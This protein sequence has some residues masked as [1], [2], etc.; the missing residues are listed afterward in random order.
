[1]IKMTLADS[2]YLVEYFFGIDQVRIEFEV[3]KNGSR[4]LKLL[5]TKILRGDVVKLER[6]NHDEELR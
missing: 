2:F 6:Q 3:W 5:Q 1:M 4:R